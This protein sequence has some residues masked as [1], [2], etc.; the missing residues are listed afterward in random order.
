MQLTQQL[1]LKISQAI[2]RDFEK[3][4]HQ[5]KAYNQVRHANYL[6][7]HP[8]IHSRVLR[9]ETE[10]VIGE[11][12][13]LRIGKKLRID[14]TGQDWK[15]ARTAT[16]N[17]I[18]PILEHCKTKSI[19]RVFCDLIDIGKTHASKDF[20]ANNVNAVYVNCKLYQQRQP[21]VRAIAAE[22]GFDSSGRLVDVRENLITNLMTLN[23]P[24]VVLDDAGYLKDEALHEMIALWDELEGMC[25]WFIIGEPAF[26][27]RLEKMIHKNKLGW[28]AWFSRNGQRILS[29]F[30]DDSSEAEI[31]MMKRAQAE[32][33]ITANYP[34]ANKVTVKQLLNDSCL[35]LRALRDDINKHKTA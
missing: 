19:S 24:I 27:I 29:V 18:T 32:Q 11:E 25:A 15:T 4:S 28:E 30:Q 21:L 13:W 34:N 31:A 12:Q 2:L 1:K 22:F 35:N 9:G 10:K 14:L 5:D 20:V 17:T 3:K 6:K 26:R 16:Y 7:L 33:I 23:N 8:S